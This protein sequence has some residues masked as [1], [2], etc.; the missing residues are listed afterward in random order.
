MRRA[1]KK[2]GKAPV[3]R[4]PLRPRTRRMP[5]K[6]LD[7]LPLDKPLAHNPLA[8]AADRLRRYG[9]G[10]PVVCEFCDDL[11]EVQD[12]HPTG[13]T[14]IPCPKCRPSESC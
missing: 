5:G 7:G 6:L 11:G 2:G 13:S 9:A 4:K 12:I 1:Q 8:I 3:T 14:I 10:P